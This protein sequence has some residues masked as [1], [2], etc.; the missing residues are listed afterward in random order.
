M[1]TVMS[2]AAFL[3]WYESHLSFWELE[4]DELSDLTLRR[5]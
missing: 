2:V 1:L 4:G 5:L 3:N